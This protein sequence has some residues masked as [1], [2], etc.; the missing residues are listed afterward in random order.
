MKLQRTRYGWDSNRYTRKTLVESATPGMGCSRHGGGGPWEEFSIHVKGPNG[1]K[2][3]SISY[4]IT[5]GRHDAEQIAQY[6]AEH[7]KE[8]VTDESSQ[9][10]HS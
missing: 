1:D 4:Y 9:A 5:F 8:G 3:E 2:R 7:L 6:L 10:L